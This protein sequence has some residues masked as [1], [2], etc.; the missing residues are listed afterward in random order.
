MFF[1][2]R[3]FSDSRPIESRQKDCEQ[4]FNDTSCDK[5]YRGERDMSVRSP[6]CLM[7]LVSVS[8]PNFVINP[9]FCE[10]N[11]RLS[12]QPTIFK[13]NSHLF[14]QHPFVKINSQLSY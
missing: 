7:G 12:Y 3:K 5:L 8:A 13:I 1:F 6:Q 14:Y 10:I 4:Q 9:Y 2:F 11:S